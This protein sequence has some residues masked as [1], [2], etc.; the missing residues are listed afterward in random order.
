MP[1]NQFLVSICTAPWIDWNQVWYFRFRLDQFTWSVWVCYWISIY[2]FE[3]NRRIGVGS[4]K[5]LSELQ[6]RYQSFR[7]QSEWKYTW[8]YYIRDPCGY[9]H[10]EHE[11]LYEWLSCTKHHSP[12]ANCW[13]SLCVPGWIVSWRMTYFTDR[14]PH[15][16]MRQRSTLQQNGS[17]RCISSSFFCSFHL[18]YIFFILIHQNCLCMLMI[19]F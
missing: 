18:Y 13:K 14:T 4:V 9:V 6:R 8:H 16:M 15:T 11:M 10:F 2:D 5:S 19:P 17:N 1:I 12:W 7:K 3:N